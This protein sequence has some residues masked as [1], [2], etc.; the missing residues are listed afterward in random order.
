MALVVLAAGLGVFGDGPL[1]DA[2][3]GDERL[4]A[5]YQRM[6]REA[7]PTTLTLTGTPER[8]VLR[9]W[10]ARSYLDGV[11]VERIEPEPER[12]VIEADRQVFE[13]PAGG[14]IAEVRFELLPSGPGW[15]RGRAGAGASSIA[16]AQWVFP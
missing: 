15:L 11:E 4:S 2:R 10:I 12:V 8:G 6:A 5:R 3:V 16:L 7:A 9:L 1:A 14:D 13:W